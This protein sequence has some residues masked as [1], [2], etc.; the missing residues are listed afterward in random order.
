M[1]GK[2]KKNRNMNYNKGYKKSNPSGNCICPICNY[3]IPHNRAVLCFTLICPSCNIPLV[4]QKPLVNC[5]KQN[6]SVENTIISDHPKV[7]TELCSGCGAC[8]NACLSAAIII[9]ESKAKIINIKCINC[10][11]CI[12]ACPTEAIN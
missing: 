5:N 1:F 9:E 2:R 11:A 8:A 12:D 3:S 4:K 7:D 6:G 10:R